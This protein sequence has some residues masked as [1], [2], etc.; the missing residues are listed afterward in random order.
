MS[1][2]AASVASATLVQPHP[3]VAPQRYSLVHV[4]AMPVSFAV[5]LLLTRLAAG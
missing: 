5:V 3:S 4:F 1:S 2:S